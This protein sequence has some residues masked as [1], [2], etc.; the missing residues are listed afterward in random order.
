MAH[1]K[2]AVEGS[3]WWPLPQGSLWLLK[4]QRLQAVAG[5]QQWPWAL[6]SSCISTLPQLPPRHT[7]KGEPRWVA[8][9]PRVSTLASED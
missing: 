2:S 8:A 5:Q 9:P 4:E 1:G 6:S 3:L 7:G